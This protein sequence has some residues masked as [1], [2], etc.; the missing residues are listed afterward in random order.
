MRGRGRP[1]RREGQPET[2][3]EILQ[4]A[5]ALFAERGYAGTSIRSVAVTAGV[6]PALVHHYFGTKD[7]LF[8]AA[9]EMPID[10]QSLLD[11]IVEG[12]RED[13][14]RRLVETFLRVWDSPESGPA[15]VS[16]LRRVLAEQEST[17][18]VRDFIGASLLRTAADRLLGEVEPAEAA[19]RVELVLSQMLGLVVLRKVLRVEPLASMPSETV[20]ATISPTIARYLHG[21]LPV[22]SEPPAAIPSDRKQPS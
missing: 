15:M 2:R 10:P 4:A 18:L 12:G 11:A 5:R 16:F 3:T 6:D 8:R 1:S 22:P 14:P 21:E 13:A 7:G 17:D 19:A 9:L 20:A